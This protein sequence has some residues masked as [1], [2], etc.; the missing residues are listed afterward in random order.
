MNERSWFA[1]VIWGFVLFVAPLACRADVVLDSFEDRPAGFPMTGGYNE[2]DTFIL[3]AYPHVVG[4]RAMTIIGTT[5]TGTL[6]NGQGGGAEVSADIGTVDGIS[7]LE[8]SSIQP[9]S[10]G[11]LSL[12]YGTSDGPGGLMMS[13]TPLYLPVNTATDYLRLTFLSYNHANGQDMVVN[14]SL[15]SGLDPNAVSSVTT[16]VTTVGA[17]EVDIPLTNL[18]GIELDF[19]E[20][21]FSAPAGTSFDLD[22]VT[23]VTPS[24]EPAS[25]WLISLAVPLLMR[26]AR[27]SPINH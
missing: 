20:L 21:D 10:A 15:G 17:Q 8:Y 18:P 26:R 27:S 7:A 22:S 25:A 9:D 16:S 5:P 14:A 12:D 3:A 1:L 11:D 4:G 13:A 19:F 2:G 6:P 24:P 23:L